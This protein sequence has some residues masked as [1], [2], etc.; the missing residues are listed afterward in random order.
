ML[1]KIYL[2]SPN[3]ILSD[4]VAEIFDLASSTRLLKSSQYDKLAEALNE[5]L[6]PR[7]RE[8]IERLFR[9]VQKGRIRL[10]NDGA[11]A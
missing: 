4:T 1:K 5:L 8:A 3:A 7:D 10:I 9:W 2:L 6:E 11:I